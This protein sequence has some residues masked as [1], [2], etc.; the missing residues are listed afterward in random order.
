MKLIIEGSI[1]K[2]YGNSSFSEGKFTEEDLGKERCQN[3]ATLE[4][5]KSWHTDGISG[6][7][8]VINTFWHQYRTSDYTFLKFRTNTSLPGEC[9][10]INITGQ[11]DPHGREIELPTI[12]TTKTC[13]KIKKVSLSFLP[14]KKISTDTSKINSPFL[15]SVYRIYSLSMVEKSNDPTLR[16][17][18]NSDFPSIST[19]VGG[20]ENRYY[21]VN[22]TEQAGETGR[23]YPGDF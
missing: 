7:K 12:D 6:S 8:Q 22:D 14:P 2:N 20:C 4:G 10:S 15:N 21:H 17:F 13:K 9:Y 11:L 23:G 16:A 5:F 19:Y 3:S 18:F 1:I